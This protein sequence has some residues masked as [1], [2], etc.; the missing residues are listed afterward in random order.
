MMTAAVGTT[1]IEPGRM[2]PCLIGIKRAQSVQMNSASTNFPH[3]LGILRE[4][5]LHPSEYEKAFAYFLDEFAGDSNFVRASAPEKMPHL[6]AV[7]GRVV[8]S[9]VGES[10][11]L[12][13]ALVSY[14]REHRFVHGNGRAGGRIV[15]FFYFEEVDTGMLLLVPGIR[16]QTEIAR[17]K[18][19]GLINTLNN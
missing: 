10:V 5:M 4:R 6:V 15:I 8:S 3:Y 12:D 16:G 13:E 18:S 17:F 2:R 9:A 1:K 7:L 14:L 19:G 11:A